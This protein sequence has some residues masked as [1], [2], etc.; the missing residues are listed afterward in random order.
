MPHHIA[1]S[2]TSALQCGGMQTPRQFAD[3]LNSR[4]SQ[5]NSSRTSSRNLSRDFFWNSTR[6]V[7]GL[8]SSIPSVSY[9]RDSFQISLRYS[10]TDSCV[11]IPSGISLGTILDISSEIPLSI[12]LGFPF[13]TSLEISPIPS[14]ILSGIA[15]VFP[16]GITTGIAFRILQGLLQR[17]LSGFCKEFLLRFV[18]WFLSRFLNKIFQRIIQVFRK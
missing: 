6:I 15:S 4:C 11:G 17:F 18:Q 7:S 8:L 12:F 16:L 1:W 9:F 10:F 14:Q 3:G 13:G 2:S 5:R